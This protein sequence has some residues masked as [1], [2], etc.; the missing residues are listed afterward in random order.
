MPQ[1][2]DS[3]GK[4]EIKNFEQIDGSD[5]TRGVQFSIE[6]ETK[7][8]TIEVG[9]LVTG[10]TAKF[11]INADGVASDEVTNTLQLLPLQ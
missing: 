5:G 4:L 10:Y 2:V 3:Q 6:T 8:I 11:Y 1:K 9:G 7:D